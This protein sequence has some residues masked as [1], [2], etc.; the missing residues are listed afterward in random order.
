MSDIDHLKQ[1]R[2]ENESPSDGKVRLSA[3]N[4]PAQPAAPPSEVQPEEEAPAEA[5]GGSGEVPAGPVD[6]E[7]LRAK[8]IEALKSVYDPE[9][10]VNIY[11]LGLIY[12]FEINE[13]AR[14]DLEMTLTAP[15]CP[16]AGSLV[17]EVADKVGDLPEVSTSHVK[18]V[19]D[20]PWTQDRMT[21]EAK[22]EL[23]LF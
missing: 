17:K 2:I 23:G 22:L 8:I 21:E 20:P 4:V 15:A 9:I 16:V 11:D 6:K 5:Y 12:G 7:S 3:Y 14:V 19:W 18:L 1:H 10:P 13:N